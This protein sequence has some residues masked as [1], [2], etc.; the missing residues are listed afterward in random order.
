[1]TSPL[2]YFLDLKGK[3]NLNQIASFKMTDSYEKG[4]INNL[5]K[6]L[7]GGKLSNK[8]VSID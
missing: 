3:G 8:R 2:A 4:E 7:K 5:N 1:M 6:E